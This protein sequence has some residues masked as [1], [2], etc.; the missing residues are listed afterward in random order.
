M[1]TS[2]RQ[3]VLQ[4]AR[5]QPTERTPVWLMRQ[6]GRADPAYR[7]LRDRC[8]EPL[9]VLFRSPELAAE[10]TLLPARFGVDALILFQDIL[11]PLGPMGAPFVYRPGPILATTETPPQIARRMRDIEPAED[12]AF[13][14]DSIRFARQD[15]GDE[16]AFLGFAGAPLTLAAFLLEGGSPNGMRNTRA[17]MR[18]DPACLHELL[19]RLA[20]M[21]SSY[22]RLQIDAGVDAA[23][24]FESIADQLSDQEYRT[25]AQPYQAQV[26]RDAPRTVPLIL[27]VKERPCLDLMV[28]TGADVLS[29]GACVD[30][31]AARAQYGDRVAFQGNVDNRLLIDGTPAE[32][33]EA[34]ESCVRAGGQHGHI[35][36][37]NHGLLPDT[38]IENVERLIEAC[39]HAC[40]AEPV[41]AQGD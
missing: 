33:T 5:R 13:V 7:R 18:D 19:D 8:G 3:L 17:L 37:L 15:A 20:R 24:L 1:T 16:L 28:E 27:F 31:A 32:I 35:L 40:A 22:L 36:N 2:A 9:E 21:T 4:A 29:V 10:I 38:P 25:F 34:V 12:L 26:F 39:R 30:L 6:A 23:Q 41:R 11:T 14:A